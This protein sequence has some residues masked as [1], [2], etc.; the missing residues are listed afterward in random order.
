MAFFPAGSANLNKVFFL[1]HDTFSFGIFYITEFSI[2]TT[3]YFMDMYVIK[4]FRI[5]LLALML[6]PIAGTLDAQ[7]YS[8]LHFD[9][10]STEYVKIQR[11]L[12]QNSIMCMIEDRNGFLWIGT[13]DGLNRFDGYD[14]V[15]FKP[16]IVS[17]I[18]NISNSTVNA[19]LEDTQGKIWVG[20]DD[21]LN[22]FR[23]EEMVFS[24]YLIDDENDLS[25]GENQILSLAEGRPGEIWVGTSNGL[26][27][28]SSES[29]SLRFLPFP[30]NKLLKK[31]L[32]ISSLF[33]SKNSGK[34]WVGTNIGLFRFDIHT[35][36]YH[37][38]SGVHSELP[39]VQITALFEDSRKNLWIG[40]EQGLYRSDKNN[41][42][43]KMEFVSD[44]KL[45]SNHIL[46][47]ME[48]VN[49]NIWVGTMGGGI[50]T[51]HP[52][53][54][55]FYLFGNDDEIYGGLSN[56]YVYSLLQ[57]KNGSVWIGTWRGLN[58][59]TPDQFRFN[60]FSFGL[61]ANFLSSNMV[62]SFLE[63]SP[64]IVWVGTENG[65]NIF[66]IR[67]NTISRITKSSGHGIIPPSEKIRA[68]FK[69]SHGRLWIGTFD[70]G[71]V[72]YDPKFRRNTY[73][74]AELADKNRHLAGNGV[75]GIVEDDF[76]KSI[77]IATNGGVTRI[78]SEDSLVNYLHIPGD[79]S[80]ISQNEIYGILKD[81]KNN[82]WIASFSGVDIYNRRFDNF[83]RFGIDL[84]AESR[85]KTNRIL[86]IFEDSTGNIW[87]ATMGEG[88]SRFNAST[89]EMTTIT[90]KEG[91]ANNT[92]YNIVEDDNGNIWATTNQGI[93]KINPA[94]LNIWNF[95]IRDGVQGHEFNLGAA[96]ILSSGEI[97][98]GGMNG[99]NIFNPDQLQE[100][101]YNP[102]IYIT[103]FS[104][105]NKKRSD[106]LRN[107]DVIELKWLENYFTFEFAAL[108]FANPKKINYA[109]K[110]DGFDNEWI[111][112]PSDKRYADYTNVPPGKYTFRVRGTNSDGLWSATELKVHITIHAPFWKTLWFKILTAL[113]LTF[114]IWIIV[115]N[116]VRKIRKKQ[117]IERRI[118]EFEKN[119]FELQQKVLHLQ[120]NPHFL[121]NAL[122]SIQSFILK[123]ETENAIN[124]LSKFSNLMRLILHTSRT[125]NVVIG[126]E[127]KLLQYYLEIET[128]RF[129]HIFKFE[130][131]PDPEID[132]EFTAIPSHMV[133][134]LV[135]NSI[136]H[137]LIQK[138][139]QGLVVVTFRQFS[140]YIE[141]TVEDNG[142]G[143]EKASEIQKRKKLEIS[144]QGIS[145]TKERLSIFNRQLESN[146]YGLEYLDLYDSEGN[147]CGTKA[148]LRVP[149]FD[150]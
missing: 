5:F 47:F 135:E 111:Y 74:N 86:S 143:R 105:F 95:D 139:G 7:V 103:R 26:Y 46:S 150:V 137:G 44:S 81:S 12:S 32:T 15:I 121:F 51:F 13:W 80:T 8:N 21:G 40:T 24:N 77:W 31:Q 58:K 73:Y 39:A 59:F 148:T 54:G 48:D 66:N 83:K 17:N 132:D 25:L 127:I 56:T 90:E 117:E 93:S 124:Y 104:V 109:Y 96:K 34:I 130:I 146:V 28:F 147:A 29:E 11:G 101:L 129:D 62:W 19:L 49:G 61:G 142:V 94:N 37:Y 69:D 89:G 23:P 112:V 10:Y 97:L 98:F 9:T 3:R 107:N 100:N 108:D 52:A 6:L 27:L 84:P 75:W 20:T 18:S 128:L 99:L 114:M 70:S 2:F 149:C 64:D 50:T 87:F 71:V 119:V 57:T 118:F 141:I 78:F 140:D 136:K 120:M 125:A 85:L 42:S 106:V 72:C 14:F 110:L 33:R 38:Y 60:H 145:I 91:L 115:N 36:K 16:G 67:Q 134:P 53:S 88:V 82:I 138:D 131:H 116:Q 55:Q 102:N 144:N 65:I 133:Q 79:P 45:T 22:M 126:D 43:L 30:T 113:L 122:N 63:V 92:V 35:Y 4:I 1:I 68:T 76:D 123:S 41:G